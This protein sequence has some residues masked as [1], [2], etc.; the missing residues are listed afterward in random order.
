M[1]QRLLPC[2]QQLRVIFILNGH[3]GCRG[4]SA[5]LLPAGSRHGQI[6]NEPLLAS[7]AQQLSLFLSK[8]QYFSAGVTCKAGSGESLQLICCGVAEIASSM[9]TQ[10]RTSEAAGVHVDQLACSLL[11]EACCG[12]DLLQGQAQA[13]TLM[14]SIPSSS[15]AAE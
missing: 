14:P 6:G 13:Q 8:R 7:V 5:W 11:G 9:L 3:E 10:A 2:L 12:S 4:S 15:Q 1:P